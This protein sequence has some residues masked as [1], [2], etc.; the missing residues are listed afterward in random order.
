MHEQLTNV[1]ATA[2]IVLLMIDNL[3]CV[4]DMLGTIYPHFTFLT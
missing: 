1:K 4:T 3:Y 2:P